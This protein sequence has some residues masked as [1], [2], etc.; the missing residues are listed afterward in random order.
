MDNSIEVK[1]P[2]GGVITQ[3]PIAKIDRESLPGTMFTE[4]CNA[5]AAHQADAATVGANPHLSRMGREHALDPS[6]ITSVHRLAKSF[7][8]VESHQTSLNQRFAV[9]C[10]VPQINPGNTVDVAIDLEIRNH[11]RSLGGA[12]RADILNRIA[13]EPGLVRYQLALLRSPIALADVELTTVRATWNRACRSA[14]LSEDIAISTGLATCV[15]AIRGLLQ[16]GGIFTSGLDKV[17]WPGKRLLTTILNCANPQVQ[18][19]YRVF[20]FCDRDV[21]ELRRELDHKPSPAAQTF[22]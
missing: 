17:E 13:D 6:T 21:F 19:G 4:A 18:A 11:W 14:S 20:G 15:W 5:I 9:M 7:A 22:A 2:G 3:K 12:E 1:F 16:A 10:A 8:V